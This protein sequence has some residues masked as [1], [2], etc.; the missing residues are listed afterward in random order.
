VSR[1]GAVISRIDLKA[2]S[3]DIEGVTVDRDGTIYLTAQSPK[4]YVLK[5]R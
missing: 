2:I 1:S 3:T 5:P 4:L